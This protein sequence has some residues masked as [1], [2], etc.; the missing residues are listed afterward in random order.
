MSK[1]IDAWPTS[2]SR[3]AIIIGLVG[4]LWNGVNALD[5]QPKSQ[6]EGGAQGPGAK[7]DSP[8]LTR[9]AQELA[10]TA[11]KQGALDRFWGEMRGK[12]PLV[13]PMA[14]NDR[15]MLVTFIWHANKNTRR[16]GTLGTNPSPDC[17]EQELRRFLATDLWYKTER[18]PS[19]ARFGYALG[20]NGQGYKPDPLARFPISQTGS[21]KSYRIVLMT[22]AGSLASWRPIPSYPFDST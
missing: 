18:I 21:K 8:R 2:V 22:R 9:L 19:D 20:E 16:V 14:G 6:A 10:S 4:A 17:A 7:F 15:E 11:D 5:A 3:G 13:E 12:T 1:S